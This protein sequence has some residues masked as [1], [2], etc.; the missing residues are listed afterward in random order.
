MF[1]TNLC[2]LLLQSN[3]AI[4]LGLNHSL[5]VLLSLQELHDVRYRVLEE[6]AEQLVSKER[7]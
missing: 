7:L 1:L 4:I 3:E 5:Q 6:P 2:L